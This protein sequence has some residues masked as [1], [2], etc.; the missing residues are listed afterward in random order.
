MTDIL[1]LKG[2][3]ATAAEQAWTRWQANVPAKLR[4]DFKVLTTAMTNWH[5][6]IFNYF[7][8]R[9]T[10]AFTESTNSLTHLMNQMGRG[11]SFEVIR[12]CMLYDPKARKH[13]AVVQSNAEPGA[14]EPD[15]G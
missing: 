8:N 11:Y 9:M 1:N 14:S 4:D 15:V 10:N 13:G 6:E 5:D 12:G 7:E 3:K 2:L